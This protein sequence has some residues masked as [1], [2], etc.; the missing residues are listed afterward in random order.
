MCKHLRKL[1]HCNISFGVV[2]FHKTLWRVKNREI[3]KEKEGTISILK[4][5]IEKL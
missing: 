5:E 4:I 1:E 3:K 2:I